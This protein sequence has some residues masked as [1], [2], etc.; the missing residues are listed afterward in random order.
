[1]L[2]R[3]TR[4]ALNEKIAHPLGEGTEKV[5]IRV[6][7]LKITISVSFSTFVVIFLL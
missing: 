1:M 4:L 6:T 2:F 5:P 3:I 7:S